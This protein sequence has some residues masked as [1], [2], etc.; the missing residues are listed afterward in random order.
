M[1][2]RRRNIL[3]GLVFGALAGGGLL[4]LFLTGKIGRLHELLFDLKTTLAEGDRLRELILSYG[5][6]GPLIFISIQV[7]QVLLAPIPGEA[8]GILGGYLFGFWPGLFYSTVG[9]TLGSWLAFALGR[10]LGRLFPHRL[11]DTTV[12]QRFNHLVYRGGFV[13]PFILFLFPGFPKDA[14]S[15]LLGLSRMPLK[16]FLVIAAV[17][18]IPGTLMLSLQG[19]QVYQGNYAKFVILLLVTGLVSLPFYLY[20]KQIMHRLETLRALLEEEEDQAEREDE[21]D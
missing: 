12:Y 2:P 16:I 7:L 17:G 9:L 4:L 18:R 20:H 21:H 6:W 14:L 13:I 8:S 5:A 11:R 15:Y 1:S 3:L 19:A 10:T